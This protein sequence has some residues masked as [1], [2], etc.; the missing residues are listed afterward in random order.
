[1]L[2]YALEGAGHRATTLGGARTLDTMARGHAGASQWGGAQL[3]EAASGAAHSMTGGGGSAPG[4][5]GQ[6][7]PGT[8]PFSGGFGE[9]LQAPLAM[10]IAPSADTRA[11]FASV[12]EALLDRPLGAARAQ[13]HETYIVAETR[14]SV[15]I[16]DQHAA[17]ERL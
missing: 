14:N 3:P 9:L 16:V 6:P 8:R 17:H 10:A 12:P 4:S 2:R 1:G 5:P 11:A 7:P 13:L 15:V